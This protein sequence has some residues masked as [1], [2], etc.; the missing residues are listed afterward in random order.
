MW[1][2]IETLWINRHI[3]CRRTIAIAVGIFRRIL[4]GRPLITITQ[5][6]KVKVGKKSNRSSMKWFSDLDQV[7]DLNQ[8]YFFGWCDKILIC[9]GRSNFPPF[10]PNILFGPCGVSAM[11]PMKLGK[12]P[13]VSLWIEI[14]LKNRWNRLKSCEFMRKQVQ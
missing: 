12:R 2:G 10:G 1:Q 9:L 13:T 8:V 4:S 11:I 14:I 6:K 5:T 7:I 3:L